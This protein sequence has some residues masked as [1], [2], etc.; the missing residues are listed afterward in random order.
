M[1]DLKEMLLEELLMEKKVPKGCKVD[2]EDSM[3]EVYDEKGNLEYSGILDYCPYK[4]EFDENGKWNDK[5]QN[6]DLPGG[7][8]LVGK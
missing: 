2:F 6:Y 7:Y 1:K 3:V 8:K 5:D 4:E